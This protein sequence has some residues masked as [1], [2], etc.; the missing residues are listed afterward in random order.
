MQLPVNCMMVRLTPDRRERRLTQTTELPSVGRYHI[1]VLASNDLLD[2]SGVSQSSLVSCIE[3]KQ[4][5]PAGTIDLIVLHPL[6]TRFEWTDIPPNVKEA[7]EMRTYGLSRKEDAY[8]I[9]GVRKDEGLIAVVRPDGY[10]GT[11]APLSSTQE[12]EIYLRACLVV[13]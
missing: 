5:F 11:L 1:I 6:K 13:I 12:V 4:Q 2:K 7:A 3:S 8:E 9:Y 10:V